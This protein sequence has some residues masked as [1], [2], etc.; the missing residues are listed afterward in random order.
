MTCSRGEQE[1]APDYDSGVQR[2]VAFPSALTANQHIGSSFAS[3]LDDEGVR[4]DVD[5]RAKKKIAID[6][7]A[8]KKSWL[9]KCGRR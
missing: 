4:E 2:E 1:I 9:A 8:K 3:F 7:L 5:L 6:L